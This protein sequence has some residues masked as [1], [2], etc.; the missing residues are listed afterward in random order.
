MGRPA[1]AARRPHL[2]RPS[3]SSSRFP[4]RSTLPHHRRQV[5]LPRVREH[6]APPVFS[7]RLRQ[8]LFPVYAIRSRHGRFYF[9]L[10]RA[11]SHSASSTQLIWFDLCLHREGPN[12][13]CLPA[14][15]SSFCLFSIQSAFGPAH[16]PLMLA[17]FW[18]LLLPG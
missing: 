2:P 1:L 6:A 4:S 12:R 3:P 10:L 11:S 14:Q 9:N 17:S 18:H 7:V 15:Q 16:Q 8:Y 5:T 13:Q